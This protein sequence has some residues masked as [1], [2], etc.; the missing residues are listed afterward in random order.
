MKREQ[1]GW[2]AEVTEKCWLVVPTYKTIDYTLKIPHLNY[3]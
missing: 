1:E 3:S 2:S